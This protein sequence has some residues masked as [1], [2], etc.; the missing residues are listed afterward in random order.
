MKQN[1]LYLILSGLVILVA[2]TA[3]VLPGQKI[4][5]APTID[6]N[7]LATHTAGTAQASA[8]QTKQASIPTP[9][10][11]TSTPKISP[12]TGTSLVAL[13]DQ[14]SLFIDTKAGVQVTIS[15]GWLPV[16]INEDEYYKAFALDVVLASPAINDRLT[17]IQSNDSNYFRLDAIDIRPDHVVNG[18]ISDISVIFEPGDFRTLENGLRLK[19]IK[20]AHL[21]AIDFYPQNFRRLPMV[22]EY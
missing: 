22:Q 14:S 19:E 20:K 7:I 4:P 17:R 5:T 18:I 11:P 16:R 8:E 10:S 2:I 3:C 9:I 13:A 6:P 12:I 1:I 21:K 15:P